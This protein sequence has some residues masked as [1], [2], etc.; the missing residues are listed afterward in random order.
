LLNIAQEVSQAVRYSS[1]TFNHAENNLYGQQATNS[2]VS[3]RNST[4][5]AHTAAS[6]F[7]GQSALSLVPLSPSAYARLRAVTGSLAIVLHLDSHQGWLVA[8]T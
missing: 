8:L 4:K 7:S 1:P 2:T 3:Q 5:A 6:E